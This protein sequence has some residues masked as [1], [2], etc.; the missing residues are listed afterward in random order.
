VDDLQKP[1]SADLSGTHPCRSWFRP[2]PYSIDQQ[3]VETIE[4]YASVRLTHD[5]LLGRVDAEHPA[6]TL[7]DIARPF[8]RRPISLPSMKLYPFG[9]M[10]LPLQ[11]D[12]WFRPH[13]TRTTKCQTRKAVDGKR[14]A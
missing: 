2:M 3:L 1:R 12:G 11:C 14:H 4:Q 9:C 10:T 8:T 5:G 7:R 6:A 13:L